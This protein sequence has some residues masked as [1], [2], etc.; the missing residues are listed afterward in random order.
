MLFSKVNAN[1][2]T[3]MSKRDKIYDAL[4]AVLRAGLGLENLAAET[5]SL[6]EKEWN[7]LY[8]IS[9]SHG[10]MAVCYDAVKEH[11][12]EIGVPVDTFIRWTYMAEQEEKQH[13]KQRSVISKLDT[14]FGDAGLKFILLKGE[15]VGRYYPDSKRRMCNDI[16]IYLGPSYEKSCEVLSSHGIEFKKDSPRHDH[17]F[18]DGILVE[19]HRVLSEFRIR[20]TDKAIEKVLLAECNK[21][22]S[23]SAGQN[24]APKR[25]RA[26][27]YPTVDFNTIFLPWHSSAHFMFENVSLKQIVDW[28]MFLMA[29]KENFNEGL[30]RS[31]NKYSSGKISNIITAICIKKMGI[32]SELFPGA[33]VELALQEPEL[34]VEKV[35]NYIMDIRNDKDIKGHFFRD[36]FKKAT[37][38]WKE[39]WKFREVYN[40]SLTKLYSR[41]F[42][43]FIYDRFAYKKN[44]K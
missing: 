7:M 44:L 4:F 24:A 20:K 14:I 37:R 16:D 34:L 10:V 15:S 13:A 11:W 23:G 32:A 17:L 42:I 36:R 29:E 12:K 38:I 43:W 28:A 40:L 8:E 27:V 41:K 18:I 21:V 5:L 9:Y 19:N 31:V 26:A 6:N 25:F 35:F 2:A 33:A 3:V 30:Y 1:F 39:R 22:L